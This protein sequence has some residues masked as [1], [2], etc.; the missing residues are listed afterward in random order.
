MEYTKTSLKVRFKELL[1]I[2]V[3]EKEEK[4]GVYDVIINDAECMYNIKE[5]KIFKLAK[6]PSEKEAQ[7]KQDELV[8]KPPKSL[9]NAEIKLT[10]AQQGEMI[11]WINDNS[12]YTELQFFAG[13]KNLIEKVEELIA[14]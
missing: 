1:A 7:K 11:K 10:K 5:G 8:G 2:S 13:D 12:V 9:K 3:Q 6:L 4:K 14:R